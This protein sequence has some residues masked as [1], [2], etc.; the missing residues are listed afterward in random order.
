VADDF[1]LKYPIQ[2]QLLTPGTRRRSGLPM[3][4]GVR[5]VVAHDT[6]NPGSTAAANVRYYENSRN[7]ESAS[8]HLFVDDR[9]IIECIPAL[10][11]PPEKA[12][13]V[14]YNV[15]TD[16]QMY[17]VNAND[18]AVGVEY[19]YGPNIDADEAYRR[20]VWVIA[21]L[22]HRFGL[23][24]ATRIVG[25]AFLDPNRKTDPIVGLARSRRTY[26]QL[27][28]DIPLEY[29]A[30]RQAAAQAASGPGTTIP[31][32][33]QAGTVHATARLNVRKDAPNRMAHVVS[34]V[35][36]G[37]ELPYVGWVVDGEPVNGNPKWFR[38]AHGNF[39]WSGATS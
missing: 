30:C 25:H 14:L 7:A 38:D 8:A 36:A 9:Q 32:V 37:G 11:A 31:F 10:T 13:H 33:N 1:L 18:A 5:F 29:G 27:L 35:A 4:P 39:F 26:E 16:N 3:A 23:D 34:T 2:Q 24:P 12:W 21:Y 6:G 17:G 22:C 19:C 15:I 20:Y 28:R